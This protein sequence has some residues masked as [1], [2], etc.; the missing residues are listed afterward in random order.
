MYSEMEVHA[1]MIFRQLVILK[2]HINYFN[3]NKPE[4]KCFSLSTFLVVKV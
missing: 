4:K 2:K 3:Q 1:Q